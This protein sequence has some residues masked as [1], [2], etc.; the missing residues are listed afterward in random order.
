MG[1]SFPTWIL[2]VWLSRTITDG[3]EST[4]TRPSPASALRVERMVSGRRTVVQLKPGKDGPMPDWLW[5]SSEKS[6]L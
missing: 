5:L 2:A 6:E 3:E 1:T 4:L